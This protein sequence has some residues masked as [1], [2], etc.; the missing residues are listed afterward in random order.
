MNDRQTVNHKLLYG[1]DY[2][3]INILKD[4]ISNMQKLKEQGGV[5]KLLC[6]FI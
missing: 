2:K 1:T 3:N 4:A 6:Q 5:T